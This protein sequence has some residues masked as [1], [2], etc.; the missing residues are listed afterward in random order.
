LPNKTAAGYNPM[1]RKS[2]AMAV[3]RLRLSTVLP[4]DRWN[5]VLPS[6]CSLPGPQQHRGTP[7]RFAGKASI[8]G[9]AIL[10]RKSW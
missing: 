9:L 8:V 3:W 2:A 7:H 1:K 6:C 5:H 10:A 4:S